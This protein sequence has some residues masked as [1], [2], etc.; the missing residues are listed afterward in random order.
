MFQA[1]YICILG[2][3][4]WRARARTLSL[5]QRRHWRDTS[6]G[7][8]LFYLFAL[9]VCRAKHASRHAVNFIEHANFIM[10]SMR[11]MHKRKTKGAWC[12]FF[13]QI[14]PG[15]AHDFDP[16]CAGCGCGD[17]RS[18]VYIALQMKRRRRLVFVCVH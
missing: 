6:L 18:K 7:K 14:M 17:P 2:V 13:K 15:T 8:H 1:R 10:C 9:C 5:I 16:P 3:D 11:C 12:N 4:F